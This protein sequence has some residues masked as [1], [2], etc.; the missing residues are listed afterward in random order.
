MKVFAG[1][2]QQVTVDYL[3]LKDPTN[4]DSRTFAVLMGGSIPKG[5]SAVGIEIGFEVH[6]FGE[7]PPFVLEADDRSCLVFVGSGCDLAVVSGHLGIP[8][9]PEYLGRRYWVTWDPSGNITIYRD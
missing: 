6:S 1:L 5:V 4:T 2:R 3:T 7:A 9:V 8:M